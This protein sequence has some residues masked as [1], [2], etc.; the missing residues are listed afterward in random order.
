MI[1]GLIT[2][3]G[4]SKGI[5]NKNI[6]DVGGKPLLQHSFETAVACKT[7]DRI[8]LST[9]MPT[10]IELAGQ[11]PRLEVPFVRPKKLCLDDSTQI[12]V[13]THFLDHLKNT[14][15]LRPDYLVLLQPTCPLRISAEIDSA[16]Q[17]MKEQGIES[18][19][20]VTE[21]MHHPADY[22]YRD[23]TSPNK[24]KWVMR[25]PEWHQRQEFPKIYFNTGALYICSCE[26]L[27][28]EQRFFD[29]KSYLFEMSEETIFDVD[30]SFDLRI[31][32]GYLTATQ[33][34]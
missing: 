32:R 8:F 11:F 10:A 33:S 14:E 18:L 2:A 28:R 17:L 9:D 13:V 25:S 31:L 27:L 29:E 7:L 23:E 26:Y 22:L 1:V 16:V 21:V 15:G 5:P 34:F 30:S 19:M 3:R 4:G 6:V 12:E 24:F 20:G